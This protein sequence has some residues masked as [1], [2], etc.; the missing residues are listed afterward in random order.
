[1]LGIQTPFHCDNCSPHFCVP[2][3]SSTSNASSP[4][5]ADLFQDPHNASSGQSSSPVGYNITH[6][7]NKFSELQGGFL[8]LQSFF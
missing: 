3:T 1:M 7:Y 8:N 4:I 2:S 5:P 6:S